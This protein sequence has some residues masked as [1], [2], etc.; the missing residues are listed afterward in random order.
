V[1]VLCVLKT[2]KLAENTQMIKDISTKRRTTNEI[3]LTGP[4]GNAYALMGIF[5][6]Y[7]KRHLKWTSEETEAALTE[8]Q[9]G[10]YDNLVAV[11]DKHLGD[12]F[13]LYR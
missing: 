7:V 12:Y 8:M 9:S 4:Q 13:T 3:D 11:F 6:D 2:S 1:T 10:D 5:Q